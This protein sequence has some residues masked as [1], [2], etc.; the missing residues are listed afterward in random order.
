MLNFFLVKN[1]VSTCM[2]VFFLTKAV[3]AF[4]TFSKEDVYFGVQFAF[5]SRVL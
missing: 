2:R 1:S 4:E 3:I 5:K